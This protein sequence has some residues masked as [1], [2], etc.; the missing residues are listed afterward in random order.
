MTRRI[1]VLSVLFMFALAVSG[2]AFAAGKKQ[3]VKVGLLVPLTNIGAIFGSSMLNGAKAAINEYNSSNGKFRIKYYV[4]DT[5]FNPQVGSQKAIKLIE[6]TRVDVLIGVLGTQI[7]Q[8]VF[9]VTSKKGVIYMNPTY[10]PGGLC[11]RY[12][13]STGAVINQQ[14]GEFIPWI[15][16]KFGSKFYLI[17]SDYAWP[18][19]SFALAKKIIAS[20]GGKVVG[21]EYVGFGVP[22]FSD[23]LR[24]CMAAKPDALIFLVAGTDGVTFMKQVSDFGMKKMMGI[25]SAGFTELATA[26][27]SPETAD[28]IYTFA[29]YF[30]TVDTPENKKFIADYRKAAGKDDLVDLFGVNMYNN[31]NF[32]TA[33]LERAGTKDR[34]A[35]AKALLEVKLKSPSGEIFFD[36]R[37][38]YAHL[39]SF[40]GVCKKD[41]WPMFEIIED[42]GILAPE[43]GCTVR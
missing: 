23:V 26:G 22:D 14:F 31:V 6:Q 5:A 39:R 24:R 3:V 7:R 20:E 16:K 19:E 4:E 9:N 30:M 40:I 10:D 1:L 11:D 25:T 41:I 29:D 27:L 35:V 17:G 36:P 12:Y 32:Y 38:Q 8:A 43:P 37:N 2:N 21:E 15:I 13:F 34:D 28:G 18:R 33:A 42:Y